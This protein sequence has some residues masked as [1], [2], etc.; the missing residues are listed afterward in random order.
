MHLYI[1][2]RWIVT[3]EGRPVNINEY[4][5]LPSLGAYFLGGLE[6]LG[7]TGLF[8]GSEAQVSGVGATNLR[9]N[10]NFILASNFLGSR[11]CGFKIFHSSTE[12]EYRPF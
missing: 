4:F 3:P 5:F 8:W 10:K 6:A 11:A 12:D 9:V 1:Y 2:Y 7:D